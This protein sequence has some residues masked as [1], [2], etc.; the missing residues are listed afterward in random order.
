MPQ[1]EAQRLSES[2]TLRLIFKNHL[3]TS[4]EVTLDAGR[5]VG[6]PMVLDKVKELS[7]K[8][9]IFNKQ[10]KGFGLVISIPISQFTDMESD[11]LIAQNM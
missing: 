11:T 6:M 7:G 8:M 1:N 4:D 9:K 10:N 2:Q 5:G 3:S